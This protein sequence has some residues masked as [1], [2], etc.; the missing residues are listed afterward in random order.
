VRCLGHRTSSIFGLS[1]VYD[2]LD[3]RMHPTK[4]MS[5]TLSGDVAG[6]GGSVRY[7]RLTANLALLGRWAMV[8]S[9]RLRGEGGAI[10]AGQPLNDPAIDDVRLTDRF[11]LGQPQM[12][13]FDIRGVGPRVL[14]KH[15]TAISD[16]A[17]AP[18]P[19][20]ATSGSMTRWAASITTLPTPKS[21]S[22]GSGAREMGLRPSIFVDAGAVF[23]VA[24]RDTGQERCC[25]R[26]LTQKLTTSARPPT[27]R[28]TTCAEVR[29][30]LRGR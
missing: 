28:P 5:W 29:R 13:G 19:P 11:F 24:I 9:S 20:I 2:T 25:I 14:R 23:G 17:V 27:G 22:A 6:P 16:G 18:S 1:L 4:G 12:R 7:A 21:R 30:G 15:Y 8:S 10:G 26:C 3:N